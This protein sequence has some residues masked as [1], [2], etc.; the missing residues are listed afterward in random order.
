MLALSPVGTQTHMQ[1]W[2]FRRCI[3]VFNLACRRPH[4]PKE[5]WLR[6]MMVDLNISI[7][8]RPKHPQPD[9]DTESECELDEDEGG[10]ELATEDECL[11]REARQVIY[12]SAVLG[13]SGCSKL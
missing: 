10:E 13:I 9:A 1:A 7:A 3:S 2:T 8:S 4:L 5:H 6:D 12:A 11:A